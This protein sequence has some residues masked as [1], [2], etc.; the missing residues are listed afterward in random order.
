MGITP[1]VNVCEPR[2]DMT[3]SAESLVPH[4]LNEVLTDLLLI[5]RADLKV[6]KEL[7]TCSNH[8]QLFE[9]WK[10]WCVDFHRSFLANLSL[11]RDFTFR[12]FE[13]MIKCEPSVVNIAVSLARQDLGSFLDEH[14]SNIW[15][16]L[17]TYA[18]TM[19]PSVFQFHFV[20]LP[21]P[22]GN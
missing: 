11:I 9:V 22:G 13:E 14:F 8:A 2:D 4:I 16:N 17:E 20:T 6:F 18:S 12:V 21:S 10:N 5:F 3:L 15:N 7:A 1:F 19:P